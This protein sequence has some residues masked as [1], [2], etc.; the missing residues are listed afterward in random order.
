VSE[1]PLPPVTAS[2]D[3][4]ACTEAINPHRTGC[5][6]VSVGLQS[7]GYLPDGHEVSAVVTFAGAPAAP[8]PASV[9]TGHQL[10][11]VKT[12]G[13]TFPNGDAW[14]CVTC[15]VPAANQVGRNAAMDY[16]QPFNDGK[17][18]LVGTNIVDCGAHAL[19]DPSC[20]PAEVHIYPIRFDNTADGSGKGGNI[21]ELRLHPDNIHL[22]FS[23]F[24]IN[25][26]AI[27]QFAYF[28]RL[29]FDAHPTTGT[30]LAPRYDI[31]DVTRLFDPTA[32]Q[33]VQVDPANPSQLTVNPQAISVGELRGFS[34]DGTEVLY[35]GYPA[36]SSNI[37]VFAA[38]LKTG[39]VR[40]LTSNPE[41]TDPVDMSPDGQWLVAMDTR[42]S[43]RQEFLA[44]MRNVP[45]ITDLITTGAVA[46]VRNNGD[47]R[48]FQP[49]LIDRYG[50]RG[51]YQGQQLNASGD[52]G[53]GAVNDPNWNGEADP[54][55]SPDG[56]AVVYWQ[57]LAVSPA[58]G[59]ANPLPCEKSTEPG[60][61]TARMMIARLTGLN[62][63]PAPKVAPVS[64]NVPWGT[65]YVPG[66]AIPDRPH[67]PAGTYTLAGAKLGSATV[68]ITETPDKR[69]VQ[70]VAVTY[71]GYS[72][73]G[74]NILNGTEKVTGASPSLTVS[75]LDWYTDLT[76]TGGGVTATKK[77]SADGFHLTIDLLTNIFDATGTLTTT[78]N[79]HAFHQP[80]NDT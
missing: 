25:N 68:T 55:W 19:A 22:G 1:L 59:G 41:Y 21:R 6:G 69:A 35:I 43:D 44:A 75:K 36:E 58:C 73:D 29:S 53:P 77:T 50:D 72:S 32:T 67:P 42:G 18:A 20:T 57:A 45:P 61:R 56:T 70:T 79:G 33:P 15:G 60:G 12:D 13:T 23:S 31:V 66:S 17:R 48:F 8:D 47:R 49:I 9:Y 30:P 3:A 40:R 28:G 11:I 7:G 4:G 74:T 26:G 27:G 16:P 39:K 71:K 46:S 10:I 52:G 34:K 62:P 5:V 80:A 51:S 37:D 78:I 38:N 64:D 76:E 65:K 63:S 14:K 54:R 24:T 2:T